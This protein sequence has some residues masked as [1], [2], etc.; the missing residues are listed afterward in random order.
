MAVPDEQAEAAAMLAGAAGAEPV[1]THISAVFIGSE[2]VLKLR[3]AV[4]L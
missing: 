1:E 4:R 2:R 3:K